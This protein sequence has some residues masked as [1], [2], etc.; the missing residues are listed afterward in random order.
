MTTL[1]RS[2]A[3]HREAA[4]RSLADTITTTPET[5]LELLQHLNQMWQKESA[6]HTDNDRT[7]IAAVTAL[8]P[9]LRAALRD[10]A[11]NAG[12]YAAARCL[13]HINATH[14]A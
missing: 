1:T 3:R 5:H 2:L 7:W 12:Q 14:A 13:T 8:D 10:R 9:H 11:Y 4:A 6:D